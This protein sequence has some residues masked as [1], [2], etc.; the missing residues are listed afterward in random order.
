MPNS[1]VDRDIYQLAY[2]IS[3]LADSTAELVKS[4][5]N[6]MVGFIVE[7]S[8]LFN[9]DSLNG[10]PSSSG[11]LDDDGPFN[12]GYFNK[13]SF[14]ALSSDKASFANALVI[15]NLAY[16]K[17]ARDTAGS[18]NDNDN[19]SRYNVTARLSCETINNWVIP[20]NQLCIAPKYYA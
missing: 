17:P 12:S 14:H 10:G 8:N 13:A 7:A 15:Y 9:G 20:Y 5:F 3:R 19:D 1:Y 11:S 4:T 2:L 18:F 6:L 16:D